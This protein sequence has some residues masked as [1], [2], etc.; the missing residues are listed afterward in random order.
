MSYDSSLDDR[1]DKREHFLEMLLKVTN[2]LATSKSLDDALGRLVNLTTST[3]NAERGTIF[4]NDA[5]TGELYSRIAQGSF[6]REI[7]ILNTKGIAGWAFS[8]DDGV[9]INDAYSDDRFDKSVDM[10]TGF[11]TKSILCAPLRTPNGE[12]IGVSQIL[13]KVDGEFT[14]QDLGLLEAMTTQAAVAIQGNVIVEQIESSRKQELEFLDV[15]SQISSEIELSPLLAKIMTTITTMLDADRSTLFINDESTNELYTE[16]GEGLGKKDVIRFP[17]HMGIAGAVFKSGEVM[18]IPYAYADL[19]FNP[20]FDKQTGYFTRS[21]LCVP[22]INKDGKVIGVS[23]VLNKHGGVFTDEDEKRLKAFTSQISIGI[24]NAKLFADVQNTMNYNES[25][26][27]SMSNGVITINEEGKIATC[28]SSSIDMMKI[29]R[30]DEVIGQNAIEFFG[31]ENQWLSEKLEA[32]EDIDILPDRELTFGDETVSLNITLLPLK[33]SEGEDLGSMIMLEDISNEKRMK[34]TMSRYMDPALADQLLD[35]GSQEDI[36]GGKQGVGTVLFS[37]IRSFTTIT[38]ELG[39]Q[40]TVKLLNEYFEVM[41]DVITGEGGMLDKFIGDA[42]MAIFGTP[43]PHEDDPDRGVRAAIKM[44]TDLKI[45]NAKRASEGKPPIDHGMGVNTDAIVSGNIGSSKRMDYTVI[46]DGVNTAARLESACKQYGAHIL[47][48]NYTLD[49]CKGTYR[50]R[51]IDNVI[52]KGKTEPVGVFEVLDYHDD[53]SFPNMIDAVGLFNNGVKY[54][55]EANWDAAIGQFQEALKCYD[56]DKPSQ[57]Y[58]E[59]CEHMK[60]NPPEGD[61][62]GVWVL[63][64]K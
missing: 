28:N 45:F 2:D 35:D 33:G 49:A 32:V 6:V 56:K 51:N 62:D 29:Y 34:S 40:G 52:V 14:Q 17:N 41:V 43:V 31:G 63:T 27:S 54:W 53:E 44:M 1:F 47:V 20:T 10:R 4:L 8:N 57:M 23:Q 13:N 22:V 21:V 38:E 48:S 59:R 19:R 37:D 7:R 55:N 16:V 50:T 25:I 5:S 18:N 24:E 58:I 30:T 12:T 64:S 42:I 61:W 11:R 9:V 3:I 15:V 26:L 36:M 46:G 39:A 60:E